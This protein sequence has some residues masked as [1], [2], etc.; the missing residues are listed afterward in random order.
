MCPNNP[1]G[2][3]DLYPCLTTAPIHRGRPRSIRAPAAR[4]DHAERHAQGGTLQTSQI[5]NSSP[6]LD[7]L[8]Q[9]HWSY[10]GG[11]EHHNPA[12]LFIANV[13]D[14]G[15]CERPHRAAA[16]GTRWQAR[17]WRCAPA[18]QDSPGSPATPPGAPAA[19]AP[20]AVPPSTATP[21][22]T[23]GTP[24]ADV[25]AAPSGAPAGAPRA[26]GRAVPAAAA[27]AAPS[28]PARRIGSRSPRADGS[29]TVTNTRNGFDQCA[30]R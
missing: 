29:F 14:G 26:P 21:T 18:A 8:W 4:A 15:D 25:T 5:I 11:I 9:L 16:G 10:N 6:R 17:A 28:T 20:P 27:A 23:P 2:T 24:P 3:V 22:T 7:D 12:G 13:D 30:A 19:T 1:I